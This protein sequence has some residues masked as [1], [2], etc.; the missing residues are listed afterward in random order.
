MQD[1]YGHADV[2][3]AA[4]PRA[5]TLAIEGL[6]KSYGPTVALAGIDLR[7][8]AGTILGLLGPNGAGKTSL[9]S[10]VA[11]L[12]RP[13]AGSVRVCGIDVRAD[14]RRQRAG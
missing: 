9:V 8:E 10:I 5:P 11:G 13:D 3:V 7:V 4:D 1:T 14:R 12:R 6:T 2:S